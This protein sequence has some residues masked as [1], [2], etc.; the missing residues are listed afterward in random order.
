MELNI[1]L[2]HMEEK[3]DFRKNK[4][5]EWKKYIKD[6]EEQEEPLKVRKITQKTS[7]EKLP[8]ETQAQGAKQMR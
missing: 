8:G 1:I 3:N 4:N 2:I 5:K 6:T 7:S